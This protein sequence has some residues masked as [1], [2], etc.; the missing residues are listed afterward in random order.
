MAE[1]IDQTTLNN[2]ELSWLSF[3][4]RVLQEAR[5]EGV[6]LLQ[7][8]RFL[9]IYSN[10]LDEFVKVRVANVERLASVASDRGRTL[11]GGYTPI[12]LLEELNVRMHS[13]QADYEQ[14]YDQILREME[15]HGIFIVNE[16]QLDHVQQ[17]FVW[18][19]FASTVSP[20]TAP[21]MLRKRVKLPF[22]SDERA[23]LGVKMV[24]TSGRG[25]YAI[26]EIPTS[27]ACPRFVVLP[28][29]QG[30]THIIFLDDILRFC[31]D[32][33]FFM[34]DY[35]SI[36]AHT[37]KINRDAE[38]TLDDDISKSLVQ[39]ME[40]GITKRQHGRP[41]RLVYDKQ[42]PEDLLELIL[43]KFDIR[44]RESV[45][46]GGRYH[47]LRDLMRFPK[48]A[49]SLEE[50]PLPPL[51]HPYIKPFSSILSVV[52]RS[53]LLLAYP[54]YTFNHLIDF[55]REAAIDPKVESIYITLY[56]MA[57]RSK[58]VGA[59]V[60]AARNGKRVVVLVELMARFDEERNIDFSD[61]MQQAGIK[62]IHG[63]DGVKVHAK[64]ILVE[65]REGAR[66][67]G[68]TYVGTGNFNE[69]T[70]TLYSDF[71]LLTADET[72]A[73]DAERV[74]DFL[75]N[76]HK[77]F[78][79]DRLV[80]SPYF[81]RDHF[82][83]M[84]DREIHAAKGG[85]PAYIYAKFNSLTDPDMIAALY[86]ASDAGVDVRL[87]V[88]GACCLKPGEKGLSRHIRAISIVDRF[89]EHARL[90]I[91][92]GGGDERTY[93]LSADWMPRNL[94]RRVEVGI[95]VRDRRIRKLL[96]KIFDIQWN[97]RIKARD[98]SNFAQNQYVGREPGYEEDPPVRSQTAIYDY[99]KSLSER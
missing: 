2:R 94:N 19:Y 14:T 84:I 33:I 91:F 23:Y 74:F 38:L 92:G 5:D 28:S 98:L 8:L 21:L 56:R 97:D 27:S 3:N 67:R 36:S 30:T 54:Y 52:K 12:A 68:Y 7:R 16:T 40:Q 69:D 96:R 24:T 47:L 89:L 66:L 45:S 64:L 93:I 11:T 17:E 61:V 25:R 18:N 99:L 22:L 62:V 59:L 49:P 65:R 90:V 76:T 39:K 29:P 73:D 9:G 41:V 53:D 15:S 26:L 78:E 81:M 82:V 6:P 55:L 63:L 85:K 48:V 20:R 71:G 77:H 51:H 13:M 43:S 31:L 50:T 83:R 44:N 79:C 37:F 42:M 87:I 35:E 46:P 75:Q 10:N 34:F 60:N 4:G 32:E 57:E 95:P 70:A 72:T 88:R 80:V 86:R 58:V 1:N